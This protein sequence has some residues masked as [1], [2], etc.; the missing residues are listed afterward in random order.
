MVD[1]T[2]HETTRHHAVC[3]RRVSSC[4]ESWSAVEARIVHSGPRKINVKAPFPP[5][6]VVVVLVTVSL[7]VH[8]RLDVVLRA[9][10]VAHTLIDLRE[11]CDGVG[12]ERVSRDA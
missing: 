8:S 4:L 10:I 12:K 7:V 1:G 3:L 11:H 2:K 6:T 9:V 5:E